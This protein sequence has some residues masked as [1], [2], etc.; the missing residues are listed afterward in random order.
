MNIL[1]LG[2]R[3]VG[4]EVAWDLVQAFLTAEYGQ[5]ER[6]LRRLD[7]ISAVENGLSNT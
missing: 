1:C 6:Y 3:A 4:P 7:K 5:A 2:G